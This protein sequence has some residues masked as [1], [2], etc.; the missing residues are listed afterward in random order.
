MSFLHQF[1]AYGSLR[2]FKLHFNETVNYIY[3]TIVIVKFS[4]FVPSL[5]HYII[6]N[7]WFCGVMVR[8][9]DKEPRGLGFKSVLGFII[10]FSF[11][12]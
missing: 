1:D 2:M 7:M 12:T 9:P 4:L 10:F 3:E 6:M 11:L 5:T 8:I